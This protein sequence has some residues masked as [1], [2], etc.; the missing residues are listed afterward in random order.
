MTNFYELHQVLLATGKA[1]NLKYDKLEPTYACIHFEILA[2]PDNLTED[3]LVAICDEG[4]Y[5][6]GHRIEGNKLTIYVD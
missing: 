2:N 5:N 1:E 3:E 4:S 6:F